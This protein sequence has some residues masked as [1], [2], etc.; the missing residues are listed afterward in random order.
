MLEE[1]TRAEKGLAAVGDF[2]PVLLAVSVGLALLSILRTC[3]AGANAA[4]IFC[5]AGALALVAVLAYSAFQCEIYPN[6]FADSAN[7]RHEGISPL[8]MRII[9]EI[10]DVANSETVYVGM[11]AVLSQK[12][13]ERMAE[14]YELLGAALLSFG[15]V[16]SALP[17]LLV[18]VIALGLG[19]AAFPKGR[20]DMPLLAVSC[21]VGI[22]LLL[23]PVSPEILGAK[24]GI[25]GLALFCAAFCRFC[26][27]AFPFRLVRTW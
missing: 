3:S 23:F 17:I 19:I 25:V 20:G 9:K 18:T 24:C 7:A 15:R 13:Y 4:S 12:G 22:E 8:E 14:L 1:L 11:D 2:A 26:S 21:A 16:R 27:P 5:R 10:S 6:V